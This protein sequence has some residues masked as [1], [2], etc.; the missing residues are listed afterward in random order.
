MSG[1]RVAKTRTDLEMEISRVIINFEKDYMGRGPLET[2]AYLVD[3]M[4]IVRL[5]GVLTATEKQLAQC[6]T[7]RSQYLLKQVRQELLERGRPML[8]TLIQEILGV[9]V[10]SLHTDISTKTGERLIVFTL[11][12]KPVFNTATPDR[13]AREPV[14]VE[15]RTSRAGIS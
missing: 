13:P 14:Q 3:D 1:I 8:E 11:R 9:A 7:G 10:Q 15:A 2:K 4:V 6:D 5:K 12:G